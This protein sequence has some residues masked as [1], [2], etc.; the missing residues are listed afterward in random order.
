MSA[1][2]DDRLAAFVHALAW[3]LVHFVWQG[4]AL[5]S[6]FGLA[7]VAMRRRSAHLRYLIGC[8]TLAA[9]AL[10]P[11][12]TLIWLLRESAAAPLSPASIPGVSFSLE[13]A[14]RAPAGVSPTMLII[15]T[16]WALG[17]ATCLAR[18]LGGWM[19]AR[20]LRRL[21]DRG[22]PARCREAVERISQTM[23]VRASVRLVESAAVAVPMTMGWLAPVVLLPAAALAGLSAGQLEAILAHELAHIRQRDYLVN[24]LQALVESALFYHPAVWWVSRHVRM[25]REYCCDDL[26]AATCGDRVLYARALTELEAL[27]GVS[28]GVRLG[29]SSNGGSLMKRIVRLIDH[30]DPGKTARAGLRAALAAG[31][32]LASA[33]AAFAMMNP[34]AAKALEQ[35]AQTVEV[36]FEFQPREAPSVAVRDAQALVDISEQE[37][38]A[39]TDEGEMPSDELLTAARL[40]YPFNLFEYM[41]WIA[42]AAHDLIRPADELSFD[43]RTII[44]SVPECLTYQWQRQP[45]QEQTQLEVRLLVNLEEVQTS[46]ILLVRPTVLIP[47]QEDVTFEFVDPADDGGPA[48]DDQAITEDDQTIIYAPI[49]QWQR[50]P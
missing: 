46:P 11:A 29:L 38:I 45:L 9:M 1:L 34:Q 2:L 40:M 32:L 14:A 25:E 23:G 35:P 33:S 49:L 44:L 42:P 36:M 10:A 31:A 37:A 8:V 43:G 5:A 27:R 6:L 13:V 21:P 24:L 16:A 50:K 30:Q 41:P 28:A 3:S 18:L 47:E 15:V 7:M 19:H 26:A 20:R 48:E 12:A 39:K 22:L 4:A 17:A